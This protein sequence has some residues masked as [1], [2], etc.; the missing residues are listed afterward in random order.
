MVSLRMRLGRRLEKRIK[1]KKRGGRKE[2]RT[3]K[4]PNKRR[5]NSIQEKSWEGP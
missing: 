4:I 5:R 1:N 3:G 2:E